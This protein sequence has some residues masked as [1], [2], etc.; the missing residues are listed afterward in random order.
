MSDANVV[1]LHVDESRLED[2]VRR[3]E[4]GAGKVF[5]RRRSI[6]SGR[7]PDWNAALFR[8]REKLQSKFNLSTKF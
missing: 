4:D 2:A 5:G 6:Q 3:D 8:A 1:G 7:S